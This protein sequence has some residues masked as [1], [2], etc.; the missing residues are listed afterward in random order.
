MTG[1]AAQMDAVS[2]AG[3]GAA[4]CLAVRF[5]LADL[6]HDRLLSVVGVLL[7]AALMAP[8][9]VMQTLRVGLVET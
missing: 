2:A 8:P 6:I 4:R 7:L 9:V 3:G 5:A 1:L